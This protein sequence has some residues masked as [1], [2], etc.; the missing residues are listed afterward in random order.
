MDQAPIKQVRDQTWFV[1]Y[2]Q[3]LQIAVFT[4]V[5]A[6][7]LLGVFGIEN[8]ELKRRHSALERNASDVASTLRQLDAEHE[9]YLR[10]SA[11]L[12]SAKPGVTAQQFA[13]LQDYLNFTQY[14][15][16]SLG[17]GWAPRSAG[18]QGGKAFPVEFI[19]PQD[20]ANASV[21]GFDMYSEP[22]RRAAMDQ[23]AALDSPVAT[24]RVALAEAGNAASQPGF[25]I[26]MPVFEQQDRQRGPLKGYIFVPFHAG[27]LLAL[28]SAPITREQASIALYDGDVAPDRLLARIGQDGDT[29]D[30]LVEQ[31]TI[32]NRP[33]QLVVSAHHPYA[34]SRLAQITI[35]SGL[36]V[37]VLLVVLIRMTY[38]KLDEERQ[39]LEWR[40]SE[41]GIRNSLSREL[42]HR[43]KN[44]LAT[45]LSIVTL[46]KRRATDLDSYVESLS[47]RIRALSATHDLLTSNEWSSIE[48]RQIIRTEL[49]PYIGT[50]GDD[51]DHVSLDGPDIRLAPN[52]ALTLG[53]AIHEL[54]TN[55][56]KYGSLSVLAG[57]IAIDWRLVDNQLVEV[58]WQEI[59]GPA[60]SEPTKRGF[61]RELIEKILA[62]ELHSPVKLSFAPEGL[63]CVFRVPLRTASPFVLRREQRSSPPA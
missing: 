14:R 45:V 56:A 59:G 2:P 60:V 15:Q 16:G 30:D 29:G 52:D 43:V 17:V 13:E 58:H 51:E 22:T 19:D 49:A 48:L 41:A 50:G 46:T 20:P 62:H 42:N 9:I 7:S 5:C 23:A 53:L 26:Y 10:A 54:A 38:Q 32:A 8:A 25:L 36:M 39:V 11:T 24:G 35:L 47:G 6:V 37:A 57:R 28:A 55:A 31:V 12:L 3:A 21:V 63:Q 40:A 34:L 27:A 44:T 4:L 33:W 1:R 61:G 18:R